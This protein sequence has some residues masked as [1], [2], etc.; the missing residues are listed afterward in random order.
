MRHFFLLGVVIAL[1]LWFV[2]PYA[3]FAQDPLVTCDGPNCNFCSLV[4]TI[5]NVID[6]LVILAVILSTIMLAI[7]GFK[8]V[9]SK[10]NPGA[11][12]DAK[13][14][15][16][17]VCIGI[18]IVM[19]AWTIVDILMKLLVSDTVTATYGP[20]HDIK[21]SMCGTMHAPGEAITDAIQIGVHDNEITEESEAYEVVSNPYG[22]PSTYGP[23]PTV[24]VDPTADGQFTYQTGIAAQRSHASAPLN[25]IL[26]C[27]AGK[28]PASVGNISSISDSLIVNGAKTF[29]ECAAG[30]CQHARN[31]RHYGGATCTGKSYAVDFGD[32]QNVSTICQAANSCG[33][34]N[35]CSVHNG[36]HV[37]LDLPL[38]C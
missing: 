10:G 4:T 30:E 7:G 21:G 24:A 23:R 37:H 16:I 35:S 26:N 33:V 20:W 3:L 29:A 25:N 15:L 13:Q 38:S 8:L 19:A 1:G 2:A 6:F 34:V 27:M 12:K 18:L 32:E 17:N 28:L 5:D 22:P 36:N 9:A 14:Y 31:S 11:M